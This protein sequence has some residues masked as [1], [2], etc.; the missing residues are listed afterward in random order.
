[1]AAVE[2][3]IRKRAKAQRGKIIEGLRKAGVEGLT[4]V[5]LYDNITKSLGARLTELYER[6]YNIQCTKVEDGV[7]RYVLISEPIKLKPKSKRAEELLINQIDTD[8]N[9]KIDT[10]DL[11]DLLRENDFIISRKAGAFKRALAQ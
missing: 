2:I 7:Y 10:K 6:G 4:N 1:M 5:Y 11:I 8:F 3:D 9:G